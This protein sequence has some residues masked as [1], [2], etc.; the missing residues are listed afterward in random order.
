MTRGADV[1]TIVSN[2]ALLIPAITAARYH[3]W[4]RAWVF[5]WETWVSLLYHLCDSFSVCLFSYTVHHN[6][7]FFFAQL[8]IV[9]AGLYVIVFPRGWE[10]LER[11]LIIVG[12]IAIIVLQ[13]TLGGELIV[14][15]AIVVVLF[16]GIIIYWCA[17]GVPRYNWAMFLL[18]FSLTSSS[19]TL[20]ILQNQWNQAF[21]AIHS[22]WHVAAALGQ[23]YFLQIR[24]PAP[25]FAGVDA[26]I[27]F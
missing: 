26:R 9:L 8:L 27:K 14:Q 22:L 6:L 24:P 3:R 17:A 2:L 20:Y 11:G 15:G 23:H 10:W 12:A 16:L 21:W 25:R 1:L 13:V 5:F 7:D 4:T 18:G 19:V